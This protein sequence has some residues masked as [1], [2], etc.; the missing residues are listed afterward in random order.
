M[1]T[2]SSNL[3]LWYAKIPLLVIIF[4]TADRIFARVLACL[5]YSVSLPANAFCLRNSLWN[6]KYLHSG[7]HPEPD[8]WS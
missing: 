4:L 8:E 5:L 6:A 7:F 1:M 2:G 3:K